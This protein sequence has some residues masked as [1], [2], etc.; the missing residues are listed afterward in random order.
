MGQLFLPEISPDAEIQRQLH[1]QVTPNSTFKKSY[2]FDVLEGFTGSAVRVGALQGASDSGVK[3]TTEELNQR[4]P[5]KA[6][7]W[8]SLSV[9]GIQADIIHNRKMEELERKDLWNRAEGWG[10]TASVFGSLSAGL[11]D[12]LGLVLGAVIM[13]SRMMPLL[14]GARAMSAVGQPVGQRLAGTAATNIVD[15]I[16]GNAL[17]EPGIL[18]ANQRYNEDYTSLDSLTNVVVGG[19]VGGLIPAA[20]VGVAHGFSATRKVLPNW[21]YGKSVVAHETA[22]NQAV[23]DV[24]AGR[25]PQVEPIIFSAKEAE[26]VSA[27]KVAQ[28]KVQTAQQQ[29]DAKI[30]QISE[31]HLNMKRAM[32]KASS[33]QKVALKKEFDASVEMSLYDA[34][35]VEIRGNDVI[36]NGKKISYDMEGIHFQG[37]P[38]RKLEKLNYAWKVADGA[39]PLKSK[40]SKLAS[41]TKTHSRLGEVQ[42]SYGSIIEEPDGRIWVFHPKGQYG[43][44]TTSFPKGGAN[45]GETIYGAAVREVFEETGMVASPHHSLGD[46]ERTG[47]VTQYFVAK[48]MDGSPQGHGSEAEGVSLHWPQN[49]LEKLQAEGNLNDAKVLESYINYVAQRD[50]EKHIPAEVKKNIYTI[51]KELDDQLGGLRMKTALQ[52]EYFQNDILD[53]HDFIEVYG[54]KGSNPG[55]VYRAPNGDHYY[56]KFPPSEAHVHNEQAAGNLYR[57]YDELAGTNFAVTTHVAKDGDRIGVASK[58]IENLEAVSPEQL[59]HMFNTTKDM[60]FKNQI[61]QLANS[62]KFDAFMANYDV[63]GTGP[64]WNVMVDTH[65]GTIHK[66]DYGGAMRFRAQGGEKGGWGAKV[67]EID[68]MPQHGA[69]PMVYLNAESQ[70]ARESLFAIAQITKEHIASALKSTGMSGE[71]LKKQI[72][73]LLARK[74]EMKAHAPQI[75][76]EAAE[77]LGEVSLFTQKEG[78]DHVLEKGKL[79]VGKYTEDERFAMK[80]YQEGSS[81][82]NNY[83]WNRNK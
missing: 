19:L 3:L 52:S 76:K 40:S 80:H 20:A 81:V 14:A 54:Q 74:H 56:V 49:L 39:N 57:L 18:Y 7:R 10:T 28:E 61:Q 27:V 72:S 8:D 42:A 46:F 63:Y 34:K 29:S 5:G 30:E 16:A 83:L 58:I 17:L 73:V 78:I 15:A 1:E 37:K 21:L 44:Y 51:P 59:S 36:L 33:E 60:A 6:V 4:Y 48:R 31:L 12:P 32:E 38:F 62:W 41:M 25:Q 65:A 66:I 64:T 2:D 67:S 79:H 55:G 53:L 69:K 47:S 77:S 71:E 35:H 50:L 13:P 45:G 82:L 70:E 24:L 43:G 68:T 26:T 23:G 75:A 9:S 11:V 22:V